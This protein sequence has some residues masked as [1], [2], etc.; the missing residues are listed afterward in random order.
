V[1]FAPAATERL[2]I[3]SSHRTD[4]SDVQHNQPLK[5]NKL[6]STELHLLSVAGR[7]NG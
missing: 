6:V 7:V 4:F 3:T 2:G 1:Q 5:E